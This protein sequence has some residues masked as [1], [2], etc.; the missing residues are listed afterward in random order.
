MRMRKAEL[1][2]ELIQDPEV[3]TDS[4]GDSVITMKFKTSSEVDSLVITDGNGKLTDPKT[5]ECTASEVEGEDALE[6]T[7]NISTNRTGEL[8][9][10]V[11][12]AYENGYTDESKSVTVSVVIKNPSSGGSNSPGSDSEIDYDDPA[13]DSERY[14]LIAIFYKIVELFEM[15]FEMFGITI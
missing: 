10:I 9:Y 1:G 11:S 12:G 14:L 15:I 3:V 4:N 2:I 6:W 7:V 13:Y 8:I 5:V